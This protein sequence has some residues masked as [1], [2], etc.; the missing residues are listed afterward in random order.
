MEASVIITHHAGVRMKER[1]NVKRKERMQRIAEQAFAKGKAVNELKGIELRFLQ[2]CL[3]E[4]IENRTLKIFQD[5]VFIFEQKCLITM[6]PID[7][8]FQRNMEKKRY[9]QKKK[10][11]AQKGVRKNEQRTRCIELYAY[12]NATGSL[13][14][15]A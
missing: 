3:K 4:G 13:C 11:T 2:Q 8:K 10:I 7:K 14:E 9:K 12:E 5:R 6:L 1:M 15:S